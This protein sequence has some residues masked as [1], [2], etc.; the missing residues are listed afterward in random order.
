MLSAIRDQ[1]PFFYLAFTR[2]ILSD[3]SSPTHL[4]VFHGEIAW[5]KRMSARDRRADEMARRMTADAE[6]MERLVEE[7]MVR[8]INSMDVRK[9]RFSSMRRI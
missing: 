5:C 1:D 8:G 2:C 6:Q 7:G 3:Y 4:Q 9:I